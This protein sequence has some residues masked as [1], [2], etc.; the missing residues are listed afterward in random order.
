[1]PIPTLPD[2]YKP[3][4]GPM[5]L[6]PIETPPLLFTINLVELL[7][8][9]WKGLE[10]PLTMSLDDPRLLVPIPTFPEVLIRI[11]SVLFVKSRNGMELV[12]PNLEELVALLLPAK[13]QKGEVFCA[14]AGCKLLIAKATSA[15]ITIVNVVFIREDLIV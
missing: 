2:T 3:S 11:R 5:E 6:L 9:A 8:C 10:D 14:F 13:L 12:V 7:T 1:M 15:A 4:D